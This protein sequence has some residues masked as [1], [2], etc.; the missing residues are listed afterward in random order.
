MRMMEDETSMEHKRFCIEFK[1]R[2]N[3]S[4]WINI[5]SGSSCYSSN[6][7]TRG[8]QELSLKIP[9]CLKE[10]IVAHEI[11]HTLG[12]PLVISIIS[13]WSSFQF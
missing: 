11:M 13:L 4:N 9:E 12:F 8:R 5:V 3:E 10:Y 7:M 1:E 6:G 2:K